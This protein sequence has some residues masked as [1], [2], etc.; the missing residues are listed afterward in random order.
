MDLTYDLESVSDNA[1]SHE[2]LS[3]VAAVHHQGVGEALD[4]WALCLS[5]SLLGIS[6]GGVGDVDWGA[7]LDVIAAECHVSQNFVDG[8]ICP[9]RRCSIIFAPPHVP[10]VP[11]EGIGSLRQGDISDLHV[12]VAPL[13]EQFDCTN[14]SDDLLR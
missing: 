12:F 2:L 4:D 6:T 14:L 9:S 8:R 5:E 1:D 11:P 13:A 3:V 10:I 7:D